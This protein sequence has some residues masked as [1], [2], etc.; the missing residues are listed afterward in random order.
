VSHVVF[1]SDFSKDWYVIA[2]LLGLSVVF[3]NDGNQLLDS[4]SGLIPGGRV[5]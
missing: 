4:F 3:Q 5:T 1:E 2:K